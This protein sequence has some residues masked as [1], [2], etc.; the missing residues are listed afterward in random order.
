ME[1]LIDIGDPVPSSQDT[2]FTFKINPSAS[3]KLPE[4]RYRPNY[5]F[6]SYNGVVTFDEMYKNRFVSRMHNNLSNLGNFD[7]ITLGFTSVV[8]YSCRLQKTLHKQTLPH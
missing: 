4:D 3:K 6:L 2:G 8:Y 5:I 1:F 7:L